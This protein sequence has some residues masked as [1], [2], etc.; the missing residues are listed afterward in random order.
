MP[1]KR[2]TQGVYLVYIP[3]RGHLTLY[4][5][6]T[7]SHGVSFI[8]PELLTHPRSK[9]TSYPGLH[10]VNWLL[11]EMSRKSLNIAVR[12]FTL[13][14]LAYPISGS[15]T[16]AV[17]GW[18]G[19]APFCDGGCSSGQTRLPSNSQKCGTG[20]C[21]WSGSKALCCTLPSCPAGFEW[22]GSILLS[23]FSL[24]N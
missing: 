7:I 12:V 14:I 24:F 22:V 16:S 20:S 17:C 19:T 8:I 2:C 6:P 21:C 18:S 3:Q 1:T 13:F 10:I 15:V 11:V 9:R 23:T 4:S 5:I